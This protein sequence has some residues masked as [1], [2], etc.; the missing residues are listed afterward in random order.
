[1]Y[2]FTTQTSEVSVKRSDSRIEGR[3]T[4]TIVV[5]RTII[6]SPMQ[7]TMSASQRLRKS[8]TAFLL[9]SDGPTRLLL[10]RGYLRAQALFLL[11]EL[12]RELGAEVLRLE[13]LA[14]LDFGL[15]LEGIGTALDPFDRLRLGLHL[16]QPETGDQLFRLGEGPVDHGALRAREPDARALGARLEPLAREHH[17]GFHQLFVEFTHFG[18]ELLVGEDSRFRVLGGLD[19]HHES[20]RNFSI[21]LG[22]GPPGGFDRMENLALTIR[23]TRPVRIDRLNELR[24]I[25]YRAGA[26]NASEAATDFRERPAGLCSRRHLLSQVLSEA[27]QGLVHALDG[28][29][30]LDHV[31]ARLGGREHRTHVEARLAAFVREG[32]RDVEAHGLEATV[33]LLPG[34]AV[35]VHQPLGF[36]DFDEGDLVLIVA[37][38]AVHDEAPDAARLHF[39]LVGRRG[40]AVWAPPLADVLRLGPQLPH[41]VPRRIE[42]AR[43]AN[44]AVTD[45]R[46]VPI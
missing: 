22:A 27:C 41:Q 8:I 35:L 43:P 19:H 37:V 28:P 6:S 42:D 24:L 13:H 46:G 15:S 23:R 7:R 44:L 31:V 30:T 20:H 34:T 14:D 21:G 5:S 2:A 29:V 39:H 32:N 11:S 33:L 25:V 4:F 45:K 38:R 36:H 18:Q 10:L 3:A 17:A 12:G 16:P 9:M 40:E 26:V 1:M